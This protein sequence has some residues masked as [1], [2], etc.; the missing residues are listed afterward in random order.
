MYEVPK[1]SGSNAIFASGIW[2]AGQVGG[3]LR[4]SASRYGEWEL[5]AGPLDDTGNPPVDCVVFDRVY[6]VSRDNV[7]DYEATGSAIPDLADWPTGLGAPTVDAD[8]NKINLLDQ[9]LASRIGRVIDLGAGERPD[10]LGDMSVW[11]VMNDRGNIHNSTDAPPIGIEVHLNAFAF[12]TAGALGDATF[13]KYNIFYK[14]DVPLTETYLGIFSDP[15]LGDFDDDWIGSDTTLGLGFVYNADNED[16][17]GE[18]YGTPP[19]AAGYD[20]FQGPIVPAVG[21]TAFVSGV[22]VPDFKNLGMTSYI[23]Y[24]NGG[25]VTEDPTTGPHYYGYMKAEW[26]DGQKFTFGGNGRDFS[27]DPTNFV[28][29]G[30]PSTNQFWSER[31]SDNLGTSIEPGDRRFVLSTGPFTINPG[32]EQEIIFGLVFAKGDDNFDSVRALREADALAQSAFDVNFQLAQPPNAPDVTVTELNHQVILEWT[33]RAD[34]SN[35]Y[36]ES[37]SEEDPFAPPEDQNYDFEG[38]KIYQFTEVADQIGKVIATYDIINDVTEVIDGIPFKPTFVVARG[39]DSGIVKFHSISSLINYQTYYFGVQAYAYNEPSFPKV[40]PSPIARVTVIPKPSTDIL[41]DEASDAA[42]LF[43]GFDEADFQGDATGNVG[44]GLV[45]ADII[46]PALIKKDATYRTHFYE[47]EF[48]GKRSTAAN[49][50]V[51]E[52]DDVKA[53]NNRV[54]PKQSAMATTYDVSRTDDSGTETVFDG[55]AADFPPPQIP[56]IVVLD[57]LQ[58]SI[59]GPEPD[60]ADFLVIQNSAGPTLSSAAVGFQGYPNSLGNPG[61]GGTQQAGPQGGRWAIGTGSIDL[62]GSYAAFVTRSVLNRGGW[63]PVVPFDFEMRFT[64]TSLA[65]EWF[66]AAEEIGPVPLPFEMWNIGIATPDDPSDDYR[67]IIAPLDDGGDFRVWDLQV[68][69]HP[70][71]GGDNDPFTDRFYIY[72]PTDRTPGSVGYDT[73]AAQSIEENTGNNEH[74]GNEVMGRLVFWNWNGGSV[75]NYLAAGCDEDAYDTAC[76]DGFMLG[77]PRPED[78]TIFRLIT[79]KPNQPGDSFTFSTTE[80]EISYGVE[81]ASL[82]TKQERLDLIGIVPNPYKGSSAYER[83]QLIDEVRFTGMPVEETIINVFTLNGSLIKTI[84]KPEGVRNQAWNLT[85]DNSL[86]LAS[87]LYLIHID[88]KEVG[89]KVIKFAV[90]KKRVQL[91]TF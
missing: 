91:N 39:T 90:I 7:A 12:N 10:I 53:G 88:V 11:M 19:P 16:G 26:K 21:D 15:D 13:Y 68:R 71:S 38:Y 22:A 55:S 9:P 46:N 6:K 31:N 32:D 5:W 82:A 45:W 75:D 52:S 62:G 54:A 47:A 42:L 80:G 89:S 4:A 3:Q 74:W 30:D 81:A 84:V 79:L 20:F 2:L 51:G 87:G 70:G 28:F 56:N 27:E 73:W 36:L 63:D 25:G 23:Y 64:G 35:N 34:R 57:G 40:Y 65:Y 44:Q 49:V 43:L 59:T 18:G 8:G 67:M 86:P 72:N 48:A 41:S 1:G 29:P 78:G 24:N 83:S 14:G 69:D 77:S 61:D 33:N 85:T 50:D 66:T 17:G 37:Y 76:G 60:F 58:F